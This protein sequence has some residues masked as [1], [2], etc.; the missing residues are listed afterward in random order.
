[1]IGPYR[2]AGIRRP[3][4]EEE[5]RYGRRVTGGQR[6]FLWVAA[7]LITAWSARAFVGL[8][9]GEDT[10]GMSKGWVWAGAIGSLGFALVA[11]AAVLGLIDING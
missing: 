6:F 11:W 7:V 10:D 3:T 8:A 9:R 5:R 2:R 1:M 4:L